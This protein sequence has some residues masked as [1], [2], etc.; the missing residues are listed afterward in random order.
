LVPVE[1]VMKL[2]YNLKTWYWGL[3]QYEEQPPIWWYNFMKTIDD[4]KD[5]AIKLKP[6]ATFRPKGMTNKCRIVFNSPEDLTFFILRW[7]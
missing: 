6:Y 4:H 7:S 1:V 3:D 2:S 5:Y